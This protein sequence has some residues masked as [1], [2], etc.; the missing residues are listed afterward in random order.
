[1]RGCPV[2]SPAF[3][4]GKVQ[5]KM[6]DQK[7]SGICSRCNRMLERENILYFSSSTQLC[8]T[9]GAKLML[10]VSFFKQYIQLRSSVILDSP[11]RPATQ[12]RKITDI[13]ISL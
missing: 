7:K 9:L 3:T 1:M 11:L 6:E 4:P 2:L 8:T 10:K 5:N 13:S 12:K